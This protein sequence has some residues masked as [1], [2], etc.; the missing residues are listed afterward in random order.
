MMVFCA[1]ALMFFGC[2]DADMGNFNWEMLSFSDEPETS[3]IG[4][5]SGDVPGGEITEDTPAHRPEVET[6]SF[7]KVVGLLPS[8]VMIEA[9]VAPPAVPEDDI[10]KGYY[11]TPHSD[12]TQPMPVFGAGIIIDEAGNIL[13]TAHLVE[14]SDTITV[15]MSDG[16]EYD[17]RIAGTY[18][19]MDIAVLSIIDMEPVD[20]AFIPAAI[21]DP[22]EISLGDW[23]GI[24]G[25]PFGLGTSLT[26]GVVG[27]MNRR[28]INPRVIGEYIQVNAAVNPGL[29]GGPLV[30]L[31][32]EVVG[33]VS[34]LLS[35]AEGI[36][37]AVPIDDAM[38]KASEIVATGR[39]ATGWVGV[40]VQALTP[41]LSKIF[42]I[43]GDSGVLVV[44]VE[45]RS[46]GDWAGILS[47]DV[48]M[49]FGQTDITNGGDYD[50]AVLTSQPGFSYNVEMIRGGQPLT[51]VVTVSERYG[52][53]AP[54]SVDVMDAG[55]DLLGLFVVDVPED[56][57]LSVGIS[58][59]VLVL[60]VTGDDSMISPGDL[61]LSVNR[62]A[63]TDRT[64]Y[65]AAL[66]GAAANDSALLLVHSRSDTFF[67]T[68]E[69]RK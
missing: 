63:V 30:N 44:S 55:T 2:A 13:T 11:D 5:P 6:A 7:D 36:G 50:T 42:Q 39:V 61:I 15:F 12:P 25:N 10:H 35:P 21:G 20:A 18:D 62:R 67:V 37:F 24:I 31:D 27:A 38:G 56:V 57:S 59:G 33:M 58:E 66:A 4:G 53:R 69:I 8:V 14:G 48:I 34:G 47:G 40:T 28:D 65:L 52:M 54:E 16:A 29:S 64:T 51:V 17:A 41:E 19:L 45:E 32:G 26:V 23:I 43:E 3:T 9:L 60:N 46:P 68:R 1:A 49:K 22:D